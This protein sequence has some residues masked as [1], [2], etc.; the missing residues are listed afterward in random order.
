VQLLQRLHHLLHINQQQQHKQAVR[1]LYCCEAMQNVLRLQQVVPKKT[2][3]QHS[4]TLHAVA[5][6]LAGGTHAALSSHNAKRTSSL[7]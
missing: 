5:A 6:A 1:T 3:Q 4:N 2:Q 7:W